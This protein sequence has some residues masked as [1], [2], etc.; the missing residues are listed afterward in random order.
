MG[1][2]RISDLP[3]A[4]YQKLAYEAQQRGITLTD[5]ALGDA[6]SIM[7]IG[8]IDIVRELSDKVEALEKRT[9]DTSSAS[10]L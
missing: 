6:N 5:G 4:P 7:L 2:K 1:T 8:L 3:E 9:L 10:V